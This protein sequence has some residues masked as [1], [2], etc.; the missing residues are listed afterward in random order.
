MEGASDKPEARYAGLFYYYLTMGR[1]L[2]SYKGDLLMDENGKPRNWREDL[3][4][5]LVGLQRPDGSWA[6]DKNPEFWE[7][8]PVLAT[9]MAVNALNACL[10]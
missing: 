1:T 6:N 9:A 10:K 3:T 7:A 2:A 5:A 4:T 8:S